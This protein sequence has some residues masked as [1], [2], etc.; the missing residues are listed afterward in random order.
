MI[1]GFD[2]DYHSIVE[3]FRAYLPLQA[4]SGRILCRCHAIQ[5]VDC[6]N[7]NLCGRAVVI[8]SQDSLQ[9]GGLHRLKDSSKIVH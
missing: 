9:C 7:R 3:L 4:Y 6:H 8:V 2:Q 5:V 1:L